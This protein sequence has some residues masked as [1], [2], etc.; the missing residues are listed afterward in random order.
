MAVLQLPFAA[1]GIIFTEKAGRRLLMMVTSAG[2]C[3]GCFLVAL[4]FLFEDYHRSTELT[5][6]MVFTGIMILPINIKG[7]AGS[8]T[9]LVNFFTSWIVSYAFN[10][11][12]QWIRQYSSCL[13]SFAAQ[14]LYSLQC[15]YQRRRD[16]HLKKSRHR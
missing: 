2:A 15:W 7:S 14:S 11:L 10:F 12:F 1:M 3:L 9:T 5:S 13:H 4:G 6:A 8:L 16:G